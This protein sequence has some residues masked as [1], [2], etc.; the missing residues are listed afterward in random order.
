MLACKEIAQAVGEGFI[1]P[2]EGTGT[3]YKE[4][5]PLNLPSETSGVLSESP[6]KGTKTA[7]EGTVAA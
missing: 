6:C 1:P 3:D 4:T 5:I 7:N 2:D